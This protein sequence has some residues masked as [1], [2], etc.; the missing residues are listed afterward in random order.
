MPASM[1]SL[2]QGKAIEVGGLEIKL[3]DVRPVEP[4]EVG[5]SQA[6]GVG[7]GVL[8]GQAHIGL[9]QLGFDRAVGEFHHGV[10]D[11]LGVD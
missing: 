1:A 7:E 8:D 6:L 3:F 2:R 5:V 10:H 11:A 4:G 9:A